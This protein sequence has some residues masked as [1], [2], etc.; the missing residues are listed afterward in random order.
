MERTVCIALGTRKFRSNVSLLESGKRHGHDYYFRLVRRL[1]FIGRFSY[2]R[3]AAYY[4][5][6]ACLVF[7][8]LPC[9]DCNARWV[10]VAPPHGGAT[11]L[12]LSP[13]TWPAIAHGVIAAC[14]LLPVWHALTT[15]PRLAG[16]SLM[17]ELLWGKDWN[18]SSLLFCALT[19]TLVISITS[20]ILIILTGVMWEHK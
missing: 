6:R 13:L 9:P 17:L 5:D 4:R 16:S 14:N 3:Y 7:L 1:V 2:R 20:W 18:S 12:H 8:R 11:P 19:S 15:S 10:H